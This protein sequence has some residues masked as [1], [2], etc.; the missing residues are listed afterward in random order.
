MYKVSAKRQWFKPAFCK[1]TD[2]DYEAFDIFNECIEM[3]YKEVYITCVCNKHT[4]AYRDI[5]QRRIR[6][7][8]G[9]KLMAKPQKIIGVRIGSKLLD[10]VGHFSDKTNQ[11]QNAFIMSAINFALKRDLAADAVRLDDWAAATA[12]RLQFSI[13]I[14]DAVLEKIDKKSLKL[15]IGRSTWVVWAILSYTASLNVEKLLKAA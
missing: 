12:E 6:L 7:T 1:K 5:T 2:D 13:R 14:D 15:N 4:S 3:G 8:Q 10:I 11:S 9:V